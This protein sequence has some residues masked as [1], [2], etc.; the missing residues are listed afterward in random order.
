[1]TRT[2]VKWLLLAASG[3]L[4]LLASSC[5]SDVGYYLL[6]TVADYLPTWLESLQTAA[7]A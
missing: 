1:M 7:S 2:K 3:S 5:V 6:E 4:F